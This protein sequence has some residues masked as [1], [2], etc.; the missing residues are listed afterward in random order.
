MIFP[1]MCISTAKSVLLICNSSTL[2]NKWF[3]NKHSHIQLLIHYLLHPFAAFIHVNSKRLTSVALNV[4]DVYSYSQL[5]P[6]PFHSSVFIHT[7]DIVCAYYQERTRGNDIIRIIRDQNR[8]T[9][10]RLKRT[11]LSPVAAYRI[12]LQATHI[13][14]SWQAFLCRRIYI[15]GTRST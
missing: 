2:V 12:D 15:Q 6:S 1:S 7:L 11:G 8:G 4:G 14:L 13:Y 5:S 10:V 3:C 9:F